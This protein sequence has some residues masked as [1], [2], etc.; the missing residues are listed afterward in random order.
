MFDG[1]EDSFSGPFCLL[2]GHV[3]QMALRQFFISEPLSLYLACYLFESVAV[4]LLA[5]I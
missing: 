2:R 3:Q 4:L 5:A 1:P